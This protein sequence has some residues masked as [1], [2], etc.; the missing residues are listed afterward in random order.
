MICSRSLPRWAVTGVGIVGHVETSTLWE[1]R[2][3]DEVHRM[4]GE[5]TL[6]EVQDHL[7]SV[8]E[9]ADEPDA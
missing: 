7:Y 9:P 6:Q 4:A 3:S 5:T 2:S 8:L 1:G